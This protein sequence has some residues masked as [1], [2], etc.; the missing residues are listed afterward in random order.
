MTFLP[1]LSGKRHFSSSWLAAVFRGCC[2]GSL[3]LV[4]FPL[5]AVR[6][7]FNFLVSYWENAIVL[8]MSSQSASETLKS[9]SL[10]ILSFDS[11]FYR[12]SRL[13]MFS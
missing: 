1:D 7:L 12:S 6:E 10:V 4:K 2:C 11:Q 5:I 8:G 9:M 3:E 13:S